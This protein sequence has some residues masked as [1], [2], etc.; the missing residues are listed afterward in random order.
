V[1]SIPAFINTPVD[2]LGLGLFDLMAGLALKLCEE[3][4]GIGSEE[5]EIIADVFVSEWGFDPKF[6]QRALPLIEQAVAGRTLEDMAQALAQF[7]H[8]NPDCNALE[9]HIDLILFLSEVAEADGRVDA[10]KTEAIR[11]VD[12]IFRAANPSLVSVATDWLSA[13]SALSGR[14]TRALP[15]ISLPVLSNRFWD[16]VR[17]GETAQMVDSVQVPEAALTAG[18]PAE[19]VEAFAAILPETAMILMG[20]DA[21]DAEAQASTTNRKMVMWFTPAPATDAV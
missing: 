12:A 7:H 4:D 1:H 15:E 3:G 6:V 18:G 8:V 2:V 11:R 14:A 10:G 16:W 19:L 9:M 13:L 5:R 21:C 20:E 17:P